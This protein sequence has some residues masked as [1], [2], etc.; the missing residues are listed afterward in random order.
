MG[1]MED[2]ACAAKIVIGDRIIH[3]FYFN[4]KDFADLHRLGQKKFAAKIKKSF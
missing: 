1:E 3:G 2:G 4:I